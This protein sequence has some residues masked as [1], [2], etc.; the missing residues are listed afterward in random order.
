M[1]SQMARWL[2]CQD[3]RRPMCVEMLLLAA[4]NPS[5]YGKTRAW[6]VP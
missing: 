6:G 2:H 1:R 4:P 3:V 5:N